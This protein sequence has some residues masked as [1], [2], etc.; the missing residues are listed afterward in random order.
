MTEEIKSIGIY[1]ENYD[2][3]S[4]YLPLISFKTEQ[5]KDTVEKYIFTKVD[6]FFKKI[7]NIKLDV[8]KSQVIYCN[9]ITEKDFK[10]KNIS[11]FYENIFFELGK[12]NHDNKLYFPPKWGITFD[13]KCAPIEV[14]F[15]PSNFRVNPGSKP[16]FSAFNYKYSDYQWNYRYGTIDINSIP[17]FYYIYFTLQ[18]LLDVI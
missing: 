15:L 7:V 2:F 18:E 4:D 3:E 10:I 6:I 5:Q 14:S 11:Y 17:V 13:K 12:R 9:T 16:K 1:S 8:E